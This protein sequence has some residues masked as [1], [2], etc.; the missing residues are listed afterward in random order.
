MLN[1][2]A[3]EHPFRYTM[4]VL[5][6]DG[7]RLETV[8]LVET[9]NFLYGLHVERVG[10][11]VNGKDERT[12]CVVRG[13]GENGRRTLVLW[14]D[15]EALDPALE[16]QFLESKLKDEGPFEEMLINGDTATP[17]VRS[18]DSLFKRLVEEGER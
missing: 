10:T 16:R 11:W 17:G 6:E 9:F 15:M 3:L 18:L 2:E 1:L 12:Y 4:E 8:D 14:R 5:T 7:P 13:R